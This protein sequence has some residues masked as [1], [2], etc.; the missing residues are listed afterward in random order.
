MLWLYWLT[1]AT[2]LSLGVFHILR[3]EVQRHRSWMSVNYG[4]TMGAGF[5]RLFWAGFAIACPQ[6][7]MDEIN[8]AAALL[9]IPAMLCLAAG[10]SSFAHRKHYD[11][12]GAEVN[13]LRAVLVGFAVIAAA[14]LLNQSLL[15][16]G[17][18]G[19][20][21]TADLNIVLGGPSLAKVSQEH[22][23]LFQDGNNT[24]SAVAHVLFWS[25]GMVSGA[26]LLCSVLHN[27][28]AAVRGPLVGTY[29]L[30]TAGVV[31]TTA[32]CF[33]PASF[34]WFLIHPEPEDSHFYKTMP[35]VLWDSKAACLALKTAALA[36]AVY[37]RDEARIVDWALHSFG[38]MIFPALLM[39]LTWAFVPLVPTYQDAY[40]HA[41]VL[42]T[43][44]GPLVAY[45]ASIY[46]MKPEPR[47][48]SAKRKGLF[49]DCRRTRTAKS[50]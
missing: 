46:L 8:S 20:N 34:S 13:S 21:A 16:F 30:A 28:I 33:G 25:L 2:S 11:Y 24:A 14:L 48:V 41:A 1:G 12:V 44:G 18:F 39:P 23:L 22:A 36:L 49:G 19:L 3:G 38:D 37:D 26:L 45:I 7:K 43:L 15:R 42:A 40:A 6:Y 50:D 31:V 35:Q 27:P 9:F 32:S 4:T 10:Y 29:M 47:E 17:S 5:L